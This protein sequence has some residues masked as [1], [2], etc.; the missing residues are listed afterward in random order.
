[1]ENKN[2]T[3]PNESDGEVTINLK[4][5]SVAEFTKRPVPNDKEVREFEDYVE[6]I[7][8]QDGEYIDTDD[9]ES[10]EE[11]DESLNEIYQDDNGRMVDVKKMD[12]RK[13]RGF[14]FW[15]FAVLIF[16]AVVGGGSYFGYNHYFLNSGTDATAIDFGISGDTEVTAGEE[17][18]YNLTYKNPANVVITNARIEV[19]YPANFIFLDSYPASPADDH[20]SW[21]IMSI[22]AQSSGSI[23]IKGMMIGGE[24]ENGVILASITYVPAN[25]SSE[26]KKE[27]S[28]TTAIRD[29]GLDINID[30][31]PTALIG[32][33]TEAEIR[34]NAKN[35]NYINAFRITL[36]P[37]ENIKVEN[38]A[39]EEGDDT[40]ADFTMPRPGVWQVNGVGSEEKKIPIRFTITE[41]VSDRQDLVLDFSKPVDETTYR[42]FHQETMS[43][44]VLKSDLNLALIVNGSREDQGVNFGDTLNY[45]IVYNNKGETDMNDV[46]IMAVLESD[47]LD[48]TTLTDNNHGREKG[49][50]ITW[51]KE[52]IPALATI[53]KHDEGTIDFSIKMM[54]AGKIDPTSIYQVKSFAQYSVGQDTNDGAT[55][56]TG[57]QEQDNRSNTITNKINSDL[58]LTET[59]RYFSE[60]NIPVGTGPH[61][62]KVGETTSYKVYWDVKNNLHELNN[63]T[64]SVILPDYVKWDG[65]DRA[66]V[67]S[68][69]YN[70][71]LNAVVWD[72][73]R[74]PVTVFSANAEFSIKVTPGEDDKN[75][76]M[77]LL[78]GSTIKATDIETG[79]EI[80]KSTKAQ[81]TKLA[82]DTIAGGDG[83]VE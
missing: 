58:K 4:E 64:V 65:K 49:N 76:I 9:N 67:G 12:I 44:E 38:Y 37:Q 30:Y 1:M 46:I 79:D 68:V 72:I 66:T 42:P 59:V 57:T 28:F 6:K 5:S 22:P 33:I 21:E 39:G 78:P 55:T 11:I 80:K 50:T 74:L 14:F 75:K 52:E 17:F 53:K 3:N 36:E 7:E 16:A 35:D 8:G 63:A 31:V 41:K 26:F 40:L 29:I 15:F 24:D 69:S 54:D 71:S 25:F 23:R 51:S 34:I 61:P 83:I 10:G 81:T 18:F 13:R 56:A 62:P 32:D 48:W 77:V 43:F 82:G 20:R 60:D 19:T 27:S 70:D 73:G 47:F 2:Q 45:S